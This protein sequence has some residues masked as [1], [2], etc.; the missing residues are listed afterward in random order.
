MQELVQVG[1]NRKLLAESERAAS[2]LERARK[3][4]REEGV[5]SRGLPEPDQRRPRERRVEAGAQQLVDRTDAQ[6]GDLDRP[7]ALLRPDPAQP[8]RYAAAHREQRGDRLP[9]EAGER[10]ADRRERCG[11]QPLQ[12]VDRQAERAFGGEETQRPEERCGNC[13][14][15]GASL[16]P[17]EQQRGFDRPPLDRR[18]LRHDPVNGVAEQIAQPSERESGLRLGRPAG[19]HAVATVGGCVQAGQPECRLPDPRLPREHGHAGKLLR[20]V[21]DPDDRPELLFPT[22]KALGH[23]RHLSQYPAPSW[24]TSSSCPTSARD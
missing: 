24:P 12:V 15:V 21:E 20:G 7:Q 17:A 9:L 19:Q 4:E 14:L 11:V 16:G 10:E 8:R 23:D 1:G 22:E 2:A 5:A 13:T 3:L 6:P 18:Q